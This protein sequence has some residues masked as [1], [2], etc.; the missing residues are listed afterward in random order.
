MRLSSLGKKIRCKV[1]RLDLMAA[2]IA[3]RG[4]VSHG[5]TVLTCETTT[6]CNLRC[7]TCPQPRM[8]IPRGIM[9]M[10]LFEKIIAESGESVEFLNLFGMGEPLCDPHL[11]ARLRLCR[12]FGIWT[13]IATNAT[14]LDRE[15]SESLLDAGLSAITFTVSTMR[16]ELDRELRP[17]AD[18]GLTVRNIE[19]FL[20]LKRKRRAPVHVAVQAI[21]M[22]QTAQGID[23][24]AHRWKREP[25]VN[26]VKII[27]DEFGYL[28]RCQDDEDRWADSGRLCFY[29]WQGPLHIR[30]NGDMHPC[31]VAALTGEAMANAADISPAEFWRS[32][33]MGRLR[34]RHVEG[35]L[36]DQI[37]CA[38]CTAPKPI[39]ILSHLS[40]LAN[41]QDAW[42]WGIMVERI[43]FIYN[44]RIQHR[45]I[46]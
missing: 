4:C 38:N 41:A 28:G 30:A 42:R 33:A 12:E 29:L 23:A 45:E 27:Q 10:P 32:D 8:N 35:V 21:R 1:A 5:P 14:L 11:E 37:C 22:P 17:G 44:W 20:A 6:D 39:S 46:I 40:Y 34:E 43:A 24:V 3:R 19:D 7:R 16:P 26:A 31:R 9:P 2:N 15:R 18:Y 13:H 25:G 36:D